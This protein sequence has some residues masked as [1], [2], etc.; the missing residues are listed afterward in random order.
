LRMDK[1]V[2]MDARCDAGKSLDHVRDL[3]FVW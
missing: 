2:F 1:C 3:K